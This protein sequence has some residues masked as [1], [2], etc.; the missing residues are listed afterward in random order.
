MNGHALEIKTQV[1][2]SKISLMEG[3]L[4]T[5]NHRTL[6]SQKLV[7]LLNILMGTSGR[8]V[9]VNLYYR[10]QILSNDIFSSWDSGSLCSSKSIHSKGLTS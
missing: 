10:F 7:Y 5:F 4:Q 8:W 1:T 6:D 9:T 3:I 2:P